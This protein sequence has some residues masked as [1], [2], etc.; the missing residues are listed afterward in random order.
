MDK[1]PFWGAKWFDTEG[2]MV[3]YRNILFT[4]TSCLFLVKEQ[5]YY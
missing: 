1:S 5:L 4:E 3:C 2:E